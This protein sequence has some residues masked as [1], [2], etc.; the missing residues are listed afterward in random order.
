MEEENI[1]YLGE[2]HQYTYED[3]QGSPSG[4]LDH[5]FLSEEKDILPH[6]RQNS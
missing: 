2:Q 5:Q 1:Q 4:C 3:F 6:I